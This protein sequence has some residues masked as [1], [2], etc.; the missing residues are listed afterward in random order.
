MGEEGDYGTTHSLVLLKS[1]FI[2]KKKKKRKKKKKEKK[3]RGG[4][5]CGSCFRM[6]ADNFV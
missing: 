4:G 3:K 2:K 6:L 5:G 1:A